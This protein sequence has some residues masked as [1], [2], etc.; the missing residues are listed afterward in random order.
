M[1]MTEPFPFTRAKLSR[2]KCYRAATAAGFYTDSLCAGLSIRRGG[3]SFL[4]DRMS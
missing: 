3:T 2:L 1:A 4:T